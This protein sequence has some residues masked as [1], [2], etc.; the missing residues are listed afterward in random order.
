MGV[1]IQQS[2]EATSGSNGT[3][4]VTS[5]ALDNRA[6][7]YMLLRVYL[8]DNPALYEDV[9]IRHFPTD[10]IQSITGQWSTYHADG[11][12]ETRNNWVDWDR[13]YGNSGTRARTVS[14][15]DGGSFDAHV[16]IDGTV[17]YIGS[18]WNNL[19]YDNGSVGSRYNN[20]HMYVVQISSTSD[21]YVIGKP[22]LGNPDENRSQDDVVAPAFMIASQ[23]GIV[24]SGW[25]STQAARHCSR[26]ME[27]ATDGTRYGGWRLPTDDEI[28]VISDYQRGR[29]GSI[30]IP[31]ADRVMDYVLKGSH[32]Y[33]L[34]G[35]TSAIPQYTGNY[36][37]FLRCIREL[38][39]EEIETLNGFDAIVNR[40]RSSGL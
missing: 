32:Y 8:K 20:N 14:T 7:K 24:G 29:F 23:L 5:K 40:Y 22:V 30:T 25:N 33:N 18:T 17:H 1:T 4:T 39:A 15:D 12:T 2:T 26:Y 21:K 36:G 13:D 35:E 9:I 34:S 38:S 10:N 19:A 28:S 37:N 6:I 11:S 27:V 31:E 16:F 3:V